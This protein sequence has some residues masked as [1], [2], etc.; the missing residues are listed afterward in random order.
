MTATPATFIKGSSRSKI[1]NKPFA[2]VF[3]VESQ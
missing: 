3:I 1:S 2:A